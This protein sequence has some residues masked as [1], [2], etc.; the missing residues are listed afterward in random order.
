MEGELLG[1]NLVNFYRIEGEDRFREA[2][3]RVKEGGNL[4]AR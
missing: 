3:A 1:N 2:V 4:R